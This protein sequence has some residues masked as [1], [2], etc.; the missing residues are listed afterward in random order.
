MGDLLLI[1]L[2]GAL[3]V[4]AM[5]GSRYR[6]SRR[7]YYGPVYIYRPFHWWGIY[8]PMPPPPRSRRPGGSFGGRRPGASFGGGRP[9]HGSFGGGRPG[10]SMGGGRGGRSGSSFGRPGGSMGGGR[11]FGG[12]RSGGSFG[13]KR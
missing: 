11:S 10:G 2:L 1:L 9:F 4:V 12:G 5:E 6:R 13:G 7:G 8:R 3:L